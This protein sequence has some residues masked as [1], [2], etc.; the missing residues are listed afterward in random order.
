MTT[1]DDNSNEQFLSV[2]SDVRLGQNVKPSRVTPKPA[3]E[4]HL[5]T[6]Q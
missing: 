3:N 6:G 5:K 1:R 2:S 4:G